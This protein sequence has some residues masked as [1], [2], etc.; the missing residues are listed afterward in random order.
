MSV[1]A[2][3]PILRV[4]NKYS[5]NFCVQHTQEH[6]GETCQKIQIPHENIEQPNR[7]NKSDKNS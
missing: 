6:S 2:P 5:Q 1:A 4:S 7:N 3:P